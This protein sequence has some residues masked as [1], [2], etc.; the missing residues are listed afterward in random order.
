MKLKSCTAEEVISGVKRHCTE[1]E[2]HLSAIHLMEDTVRIHKLQQN[3]VTE[4]I[5]SPVKNA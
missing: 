4:K 1:W 5:R 2:K 3:P